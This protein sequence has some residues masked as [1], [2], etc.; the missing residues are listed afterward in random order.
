MDI[1]CSV[2]FLGFFVP[3]DFLK[4]KKHSVII[5]KKSN[6]YLFCAKFW[7]WAIF[8]GFEKRLMYFLSVS[9]FVELG[10]VTYYIDERVVFRDDAQLICE[11]VNMTLVSWE[12]AAKYFSFNEG[13]WALG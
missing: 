8:S 10:G 5:S 4:F 11:S 2:D 1:N 9:G 13:M 6:K 12:S 3:P 7:V